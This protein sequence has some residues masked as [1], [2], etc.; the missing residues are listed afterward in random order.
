MTEV[1]RSFRLRLLIAHEQSVARPIKQ[2]PI[3]RRERDV[4]AHALQPPHLAEPCSAGRSP[5]LLLA[6]RM[7]FAQEAWPTRHGALRQRF[8]GRWRHRYAVA[9][10]LPEDERTVRTVVRG[11][12]QGQGRAACWARMRSRK[13]RRT[14]TRS[15]LAA[16]PATCLRSEATQSFPMTRAAI[17]P[18]SAACGN[19]RISSPRGRICS[20]RT[21]R[22]CWPPSR[23][24]RANTPT[25]RPDSAPRC[26]SRAR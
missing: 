5:R 15:A 24:S 17:S 1:Q 21:S 16:S 6:P 22:N 23:R 12:E 20:P 13:R 8:S 9:H 7:A 14:A 2:K 10:S 11:R 18:S 26:I 25:H 19:C 4:V 3:W